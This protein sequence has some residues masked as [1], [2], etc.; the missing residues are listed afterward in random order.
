MARYAQ[1]CITLEPKDIVTT[2]C[3]EFQV[4]DD[5]NV[6]VYFEGQLWAHFASP[7]YIVIVDTDVYAAD[8]ADEDTEEEEDDDEEEDESPSPA[9]SLNG[10]YPVSVPDDIS[11]LS[12]TE[13]TGGDEESR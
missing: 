7:E 11:E 9:A 8:E 1:V 5:G 6:L 12:E 10:S 3:D 13:A 4:D 2:P